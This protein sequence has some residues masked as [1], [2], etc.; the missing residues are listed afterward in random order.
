MSIEKVTEE[1]IANF[2]F[3][4]NQLDKECSRRKINLIFPERRDLDFF[5][6]EKKTYSVSFE[7]N[8]KKYAD[9]FPIMIGSQWDNLEKDSVT[10]YYRGWF[11]VVGNIY[12]LPN[13][14]TNDN[15]NAYV[16][17]K[18]NNVRMHLYDSYDARGVQVTFDVTQ[19]TLA[20]N[21]KKGKK[22][23]YN[24]FE[25]N[26]F[27]NHFQNVE[28]I[29]ALL[30]VS[31]LD[32][33]KL[34]YLWIRYATKYVPQHFHIDS[35]KNKKTFTPGYLFYKQ[36]FFIFFSSLIKGAAAVAKAARRITNNCTTG[37]LLGN[38]SQK[39]IFQIEGDS[40]E[41]DVHGCK[42][43]IYHG[44]FLTNRAGNLGSDTTQDVVRSVPYTQLMKET[45]ASSCYRQGSAFNHH[46]AKYHTN[47]TVRVY[48]QSLKKPSNT[49]NYNDESIGFFCFLSASD[50][51]KVG[52]NVMTVRN[53]FVS[54]PSLPLEAVL[55]HIVDKLKVSVIQDNSYLVI[56]NDIPVGYCEDATLVQFAMKQD[57]PG[58]E[59]KV[60]GMCIFCRYKDGALIKKDKL[61]S[62]FDADFWNY[63]PSCFEDITSWVVD[64]LPHFRHNKPSKNIF[65]VS[66]LKN[67]ITNFENY[68]ICQK[69]AENNS[70]FISKADYTC[71]KLGFKTL[72]FWTVFL[73]AKGCNQYD[74]F[75]MS[76]HAAQ[77]T[78]IRCTT[79]LK[80][81]IT[82]GDSKY[83]LFKPVTGSS[84]NSLVGQLI[85]DISPLH[86][87]CVNSVGFARRIT[88]QNY[89]IH[90]SRHDRQWT[91]QR[92][93]WAND[94]LYIDL[95]SEA[96]P[97]M[98]GDKMCCLEGQKGII[99]IQKY[100]NNFKTIDIESG[101][102]L[103]VQVCLHP[104][105][106]IQRCTMGLMKYTSRQVHIIN[107]QGTCLTPKPVFAGYV[108]F[109]LM[110]HL[111]IDTTHSVGHK[112]NRSRFTRQPTQGKANAG[113]YVVG[114][115]DISL[116]LVP[117]KMETFVSRE[118][119][120]YSD[121]TD[122][123]S[124]TTASNNLIEYNKHYKVDMQLK[125]KPRIEFS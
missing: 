87:K 125:K 15:T 77:S 76:E 81:K 121:L 80:L 40:V 57:I 9:M 96:K 113:G 41:R 102:T 119:I 33:Q 25:P 71:D 118:N 47:V 7:Y 104:I 27:S 123:G 35:L 59:L 1:V 62:P 24:S 34:F 109:L 63:K 48:T 58:L 46:F 70:L 116:A 39:T 21:D 12:S 3:Y 22:K 85:S 14:F 8:S 74:S 10:H 64:I 112:V 73:A 49:I 66:S 75:A 110:K 61:V 5:I 31:P 20:V 124:T 122:N 52:T 6:R 44:S 88:E 2:N 37:C 28:L 32:E 68:E 55:I 98:T 36:I 13:Y 72:C 93:Y 78:W 97:I 11:I 50:A 38:V 26:F 89:E 90:T 82:I 107:E 115:Q 67:D 108:P 94:L 92:H 106:L 18:G 114:Y 17:N 103:P 117:E 19:E 99:H 42:K 60:N 16:C 91:V 45:S 105:S 79:T 95:L 69:L 65:A 23:I 54:V 29:Q 120:A 84:T 101:E 43:N 30:K 83:V 111:A 53:T 56:F 100:L 51:K 4:C 86:P